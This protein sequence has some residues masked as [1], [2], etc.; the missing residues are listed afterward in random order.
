L[1][2]APTGTPIGITS[3]PAATGWGCAPLFDARRLAGGCALYSVG[4]WML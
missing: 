2:V 3:K 1:S 4:S